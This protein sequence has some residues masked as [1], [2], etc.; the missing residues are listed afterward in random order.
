ME[1]IN[2]KNKKKMRNALFAS[3]LIFILL[4]V[5]IGYIQFIKGEEMQKLAYEQQVQKRTINAKRGS[6]Y[7]A[8]GKYILALSST[9]YTV[10]VNPG[11][12]AK[13][14]KEKIA[15]QMAKIFELDYEKVLKKVK[16]NS[17]IETIVKKIDKAKADELRQW[18]IDNNISTG[19]NIDEDNKRY[20]PYSN[21]ASQFIG[22]C[23]G[24]NQGLDGIEAKYDDIL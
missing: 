19:V 6:I 1:P 21:L 3:F 9:A 7:D 16:K 12:I 17:S 18:L 20:Y 11:N 5:R 10:T 14:N 24:D 2:V 8:S 15:S 13:D 4:A 23:G 22:F